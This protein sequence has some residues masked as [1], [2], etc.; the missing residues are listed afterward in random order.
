MAN[1]EDGSYSSAA[2]IALI[3][4]VLAGRCKMNYTRAAVGKG[5]LGEGESPK[6]AL[7]PAGYVMDAM[8]AAVTNPV[9]GECQVTVQLNSADVETGFYVTGV[10]LYAEDPDL[11]EVPYT[12]LFLENGPEWIRPSSSVVG[13][14]ATFDLIAAVGDVDQV[15]AVIDPNAVVTFSTVQQLIAA[16]TVIKEL[17]IPVEGWTVEDGQSGMPGEGEDDEPELDRTG[18]D[19][20]RLHVDIPMEGV[21]ESMQPFLSV[22]PAYMDAADNCELSSS[23][24]TLDG[25]VRVYAK[26]APTAEMVATLTLLCASSGTINDTAL[27]L[28]T[29]SDYVL[30]AATATRLG[31]V[32][33]G[34]GVNVTGSGKI[35]VDGASIAE[36]AAET[37]DGAEEMLKEVFGEE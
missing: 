36:T 17:T 16:A 31:G 20:G 34:E 37:D 10:V 28:S 14:L 24:R 18:S 21:K 7:E 32:M 5:K 4:K 23:V 25:M 15:H 30:P 11:G 27:G 1:F 6:T 26:T 22:H 9:N 29:G 8:I 3:A 19:A 13:K 33:I 35:S 2:G 12:Y